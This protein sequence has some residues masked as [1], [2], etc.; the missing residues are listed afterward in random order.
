V[1]GKAPVVIVPGFCGACDEVCLYVWCCVG[2]V[3]VGRAPRS[4]S[5][6]R[7]IVSRPPLTTTTATTTNNPSITSPGRPR[8]F[9]RMR[10]R[11]AALG[12]PVYVFE[13][14][15]QWGSI[16]DKSWVIL[17]CDVYISVMCVCVCVCVCARVRACVCAWMC[18]C[19]MLRLEGHLYP[20]TRLSPHT[21]S[22]HPPHQTT[23]TLPTPRRRRLN[24]RHNRRP[25]DGWPGG[26][27]GHDTVCVERSN[28]GYEMWGG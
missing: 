20:H 26:G 23:A 11:I 10:D 19:C 6:S 2:I 21:H 25:L 22:S 13:S 9:T 27:R 8:P 5:P 4:V 24:G 15:W 18:A 3:C 1:A 28:G 14:G 17:M 16:V 7:I 12:H